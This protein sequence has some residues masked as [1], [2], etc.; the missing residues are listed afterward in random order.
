M[1]ECHLINNIKNEFVPEQKY[2]SDWIN[3]VNYKDNAEINIKIITPDEM[4]G[5]NKLYKKIDKVSDTLAFPAEDFNLD[6]KII[7]G[8]VVMCANKINNDSSLY[9]KR[10]LD[11]WAHL[12][13]HSLLH[14][15]GYDHNNIVE[16]KK[17]EDMEISFLKKFN[18]FKP[19]EI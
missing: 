15:L 10:K 9:N 3:V 12:T 11:R 19:Y 1:I 16:R 14:L 18:I 8:D 13:I 6:N 7:L 2:F 4:K 5:F 17:M